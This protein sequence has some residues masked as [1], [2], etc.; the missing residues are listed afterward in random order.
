MLEATRNRLEALAAFDGTIELGDDPGNGEIII[1]LP[2]PTLPAAAEN[3]YESL[4]DID[5]RRCEECGRYVA[6]GLTDGLCPGC[7]KRGR[8]R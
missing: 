8:E 3:V 1:R 7:Q 4:L 2:F 6:A 5:D